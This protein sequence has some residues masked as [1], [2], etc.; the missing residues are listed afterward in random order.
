MRSAAAAARSVYLA[1][2]REG[3]FQVRYVGRLEEAQPVPADHP[4]VTL[5]GGP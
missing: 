5:E 2:Y 4:Q 3:R 1:V